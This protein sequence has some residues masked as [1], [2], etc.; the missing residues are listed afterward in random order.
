M[1][2]FLNI[3]LESERAVLG[4]ANISMEE[5][6]LMLDEAAQDSAA[7]DA[8]LGE[9]ERIIEVSDALEDLA[10]IADGIEEASPAE[11]ALIE[12]AGNMAVAGTEVEP[13]EIVPAMESYRGKRIA[14]EGIKETARTLWKS[15]QEFLKKIWAKITNFFYKIFGTIPAL[16]R[17]LADLRK[18]CESKSGKQL[19]DKKVQVSAGLT[20]LAVD[21]KV[22]S[23]ESAMKKAIETLN[24][25]AGYVF[26]KYM[27]EVAAVGEKIADGIQDFDPDKAEEHAT[28]FKTDVVRAAA[29]VGGR[30]PGSTT[31]L[32][33][34]R[35]PGF[36]AKQ[37][38]ALLGN[39][40]LVEK[41]Y[42]EANGNSVL[43]V[44][45]RVRRS[46]VE[47]H[48]TAE[49]AK[50]LPDSVEITTLSM[51]GAEGLID[52]CEK[53]LDSL[54]EYQRGKRSKDIQRTQK[55]I[56]TASAKATSAMEKA[57]DSEENKASV[58]YYKALV[59]F[60]TSYTR[61]VQSPAM[62]MASNCL[63]VVRAYMQVISKSA[64][65]YK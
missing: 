58:P 37:G 5:E 12:T 59:N 10:V 35:Y 43:G 27:D 6:Q 55:K 29:V 8:D 50:A 38:P 18:V 57:K 49:K 17:R 52:T 16:R 62:S 48:A 36:D 44:L 61:W 30:M 42:A 56:E 60:N 23:D 39:V 41:S 47:L 40:S 51:S 22:V 65:A 1:R 32:P 15:I 3:G 54:E 7:A 9:A 13:E 33:A 26:G 21:G 2:N 25:Q 46:G 53:L 14:T 19:E 11:V 63:S 4:D 28:K 31:K 20:H 24:E 34:S 45:D 64:S